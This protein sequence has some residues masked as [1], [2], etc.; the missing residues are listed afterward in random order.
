MKAPPASR[1]TAAFPGRAPA[2]SRKLAAGPTCRASPPSCPYTREFFDR[3][4][5]TALPSARVIVPIVVS[6]LRPQSVV[7]V[8]CGRG[9]W[10]RAFLEN[11][12]PDVLGVDGHHLDRS[13]LLIPAS[14]FLAHDLREPLRLRRRFDLALCLEVAEHLPQRAAATLVRGLTRA[15]DHVLFSAAIPGQGGVGHVNEQWPSYWAGLFRELGF[16]CLDPIRPRIWSV[17]QVA[18]WYR[19]NTFL[20]VREEAA[21]DVEALAPLL[22][23]APEPA[24]E[25]I[26]VRIL[27]P[28]L[29]GDH[30]A[31][32]PGLRF[33]LRSLPGA[34]GRSVR[35]RVSRL[36]ARLGSA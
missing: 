9:A 20:Y 10:L 26:H 21:R 31:A 8:G 30:P 36:A 1:R 27:E 24:L 18:W 2:S 14:H 33:L 6:L 35:Q 19:Q 12:V 23:A 7:D 34:L 16:R 4:E 28:A 17:P 22:E 5:E 11:G 13:R 3:N 25:W 15:A 32:Q 29:R